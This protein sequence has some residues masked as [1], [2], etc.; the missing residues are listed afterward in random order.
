MKIFAVVVTYNGMR[1]I[2]RCLQSLQQS[3]M[4]VDIIVIDNHS[5]D[6]SSEY[7]PQHYPDVVW[8][9]QQ[10][11]L[12]F[13][14]ANNIG[15]NYAL[16]HNA[17]Y[18]LLLNQDASIDSDTI[19]KLI[20]QS[21]G[22]SLLSPLHLNGNGSKLDAMFN[23]TIRKHSGTIINDFLVDNKLKSYYQV[24]EVCAA[25]WLMPAA[26]ISKVGLFNPLFH[27]YGEDNNYYQRMMFHNIGIRLVPTTRMYHDREV[28]GN[29]AVYNKKRLRRDIILTLTNINK[30]LLV[31]FFKCQMLLVDCYV[32][33]LRRSSYIPGTFTWN[34]LWAMFHMPTLL[35]SRRLDKKGHSY[36]N[37]T[38]A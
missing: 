9:P 6:G 36:I 33:S 18:V 7:I 4:H 17:D 13:G 21:D 34:M 38:L 22:M 11:N 16:E 28:H 29:A 15:M 26:L 5:T 30:P 37:Q 2:D 20:S 8:M 35:R 23:E 31:C 25:C 32:T 10:A 19:E 12:G 1:W 24:G 27:H 3:T 14:A